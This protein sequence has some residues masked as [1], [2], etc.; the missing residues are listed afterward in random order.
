MATEIRM[1]QLSDTMESGKILSW[2]KKEGDTIK[3]GDAL[4]EVETEKANLDIE[5]FHEG[6]LLKIIV[7]ENAAAKVGDVIAVIGQPGES[8][9]VQGPHP[10]QPAA[11][12]EPLPEAAP[13][14]SPVVQDGR[15]SPSFHSGAAGAVPPDRI[16]ASPLA[17]RLAE[18]RHI[19]LTSVSGTGP[20]G[21]ITSRDLEG[22][23]AAGEIPAGAHIAALS[24]MRE[25]IASRMQKSWTES[26][27]FFVTVAVD[28]RE[29]V[30]LQQTLKQQP[31][32]E[33]T[34]LTHLIMKAAAYALKLQPKINNGIADG[35]LIEPDA[36][37]IGIVTPLEDG[38]LI[39]VI[40]NVDRLS[41]KD[42]V[43]EARAAV[44]RAKAGRPNSGD[45]TGGTFSISNMGMLD[46]ENFTAIINPGQGAI[47]A[48]SSVK[49]EPVVE[50]G[51]V[52]PGKIMRATLSSDHRIIDGVT[53]A[54][55]MK[56]FKTAM[57]SPA[58]MFLQQ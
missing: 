45:L 26:P 48:I 27:H 39:P 57:Q 50:S 23:P 31:G 54:E 10:V 25:T 2:K 21:R 34:T 22:G 56:H 7:Q 43:S 9:E 36:I 17:R 51:Q 11:P 49:D 58:L 24:K 55:F 29:A 38:L 53:A 41:F 20:Q 37:N 16:K 13:E 5:A 8:V 33:G 4:A 19:D 6:V 42:V 18:E 47:L 32:F 3:R 44:E 35:Q 30:K 52:V 40:R 1:P 15:D 12:S 28:M 46:V 14:S